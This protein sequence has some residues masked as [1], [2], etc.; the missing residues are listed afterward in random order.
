M[1][2]ALSPANEPFRFA[3]KATTLERLG[4]RLTRA[5]TCDQVTLP[6]DAWHRGREALV[7]EILRRFAPARLS[8]RSSAAGEDGW[9]ASRAGSYLSLINV[10]PDPE[11]VARAIDD[12]FA[13]YETASAH[14]QVLVQPMVEDVVISGVVLT[15]DLDTG[16]P[17]YVVNYDDFS[18][19]TDTVTGGAV[20]KMVMVHRGNPDALHSPRMRKLIAVV[21][22][23]EAVTG[24]DELDI[25]FCATADLAFYVLQVRPLAARHAWQGVADDAIAGALAAI[26]QNLRA[27]MEPQPDLAGGTTILGEMP[28]WNPAEMIGN[29]PR[30]LALSLYKHLITDKTW[31]EARARMGYCRV[32]RPLLVDF[33]GRPYIDVRLSLNSF[34][35]AELDRDLAHRLVDH[36][37]ASLAEREDL[38]DKI[39]F[40]IAVTC[41]DFAFGE[42]S[43]TLREAGFSKTDT[44]ALGEAL[45]RLTARALDA[46]SGGLDELLALTNRFLRSDPGPLP[47]APLER[48]R[49]GLSD[50]ITFGTLPFSILARHAFIGVSMLRSLVTRGVLADA[51]VDRF[52]RTIHTVAADLVLDMGALAQGRMGREAFLARYGHLRPGTYDILSWRYDEKPDLYIGEAGQAKAGVIQETGAFQLSA[53]Q[54][55]GV[56]ACLREEGY[57]GAPETL[58]SYIATAITAREQAKFAFSRGISD[59]LVALG[60][61]GDGAGLSREELSY[62]DIGAIF[63]HGDDI[64]RLRAA[65]DEGREAHRLTRT[66]RL[67]HLIVEPDDIDVVYPA[68]GQPTFITG[69]SVTART[70]HLHTNEGGDLDGRIVLIESADPGFDW[71]FAHD[72][73]G[74]ITQY[75]GAN[76]H[77]AIRCAEFGLPAA[78]GCA[79]RLFSAL[80]KGSVIELN[81]A[82]RKVSGH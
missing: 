67:H 5:R 49:T 7:A 32:E 4:P 55:A 41:R 59:A 80:L 8:V 54:R 61:W 21:Q 71:I 66:V 72:I 42:R 52:M 43:R 11:T 15:R 51:D 81:C 65:V 25:E 27:Q 45:G 56:G 18:G 28:D 44:A 36:Q 24:C 78:I 47:S 16:A 58:M 35:P 77:M 29:T 79:E 60:R 64:G 63:G 14:H 53:K 9:E 76:S 31:S 57:S 68:R 26:R 1:N 73:A 2:E 17:Y 39:E 50:C 3:S 37:L 82:A 38:H 62:L 69:K 20:S 23:I 13:S 6:V 70:R 75:G 46:G 10:E 74:L 34:L 33:A 22:E 30:R 12:V 40:E 48:A 19:R